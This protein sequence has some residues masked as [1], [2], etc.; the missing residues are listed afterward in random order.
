MPLA[1]KDYFWNKLKRARK[2]FEKRTGKKADRESITMEFLAPEFAGG[3]TLDIAGF[4]SPTQAIANA[5][6]MDMTGGG[7]NGVIEPNNPVAL[8]D[9][10]A[11]PSMIHEGE[12]LVQPGNGRAPNTRQVLSNAQ[13]NEIERRYNV[14]GMFTGSQHYPEARKQDVLKR[15][16]GDYRIRGY[17]ASSIDEHLQNVPE[18]YRDVAA[19][20]IREAESR[21]LTTPPPPPPP[22][23]PTRAPTYGEIIEA[24]PT[25]HRAAAERSL[26]SASISPDYQGYT[27]TPRAPA[28]GATLPAAGFQID[29][30]TLETP[31]TVAPPPA[32]TMTAP[33]LTT[34]GVATDA[35]TPP[36]PPP[37]AELPV[38]GPEITV[39]PPPEEAPVEPEVPDWAR[40]VY[41]AGAR[42]G[43][44]AIR[45]IA[46]GESPALRIAE[47]EALQQL[48]AR[49]E[50][51][52]IA[53]A[54]NLAQMGVSGTTAATLTAMAERGQ[55]GAMAQL[56]TDMAKQRGIS[57]EA[58]A[59]DLVNMGQA[60]IRVEL[61][62]AR[63]GLEERR[64]GLSEQQF[65]FL[66]Q[67]YG[68]QETTRMSTDAGVLSWPS[69]QQKYPNATREDY[70]LMRTA[71]GEQVGAGSR[72]STM[73][74]GGKSLA[75][76]KGDRLLRSAIARELG[77][78]P[79]DPSIDDEIEMRYNAYLTENKAVFAQNAE[80]LIGDIQ[81][82]NGTVDDARANA[83]LRDAIGA[84]LELD[85]R[86][87]NNAA[88]IDAEIQRRWAASRLTVPDRAW[89][90]M[91]DAGLIPEEYTD[92]PG[93]QAQFNRTIQDLYT[94]GLVDVDGNLIEGATVVWPWDDPDTFHH[95]TD[96]NGN[97]IDYSNPLPSTTHVN[98]AGNGT[99]YTN[100]VGGAVTFGDM[101]RQWN[102]MGPVEKEK[103]Y[104]GGVLDRE[105]FMRDYF[106]KD[107]INIAF[108]PIRNESDMAEWTGFLG[109]YSQSAFPTEYVQ[110]EGNE[111]LSGDVSGLFGYYD[112]NGN[113]Q[114]ESQ[115]AGKLMQAWK[116]LS[117]YFGNGEML[118][119]DKFA[120]I[121][122]NGSGYILDADGHVLNFDAGNESFV[123][124]KNY[125]KMNLGDYKAR[126]AASQFGNTE[127]F[128]TALRSSS[129]LGM[130]G[131][132]EGVL[133][134]SVAYNP[135]IYRE[136]TLG[137]GRSRNVVFNDKFASW[138]NDNK[139]KTFTY[140]GAEYRI[141]PDEPIVAQHQ[142][143]IETIGGFSLG[144]HA[145][146]LRVRNTE[147]GKEE[148]LTFD[149]SAKL[150]D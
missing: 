72:I 123:N 1:K 150:R 23:Q 107:K 67:K 95:Y 19:V 18:Q 112:E 134:R 85:P 43:Y 116:D 104:T 89:K 87:P 88:A 32:V 94:Q 50:Y 137:T 105:R 76:M 56:I 48:G 15:I 16:Q 20:G 102:Q 55:Q 45:D 52:D 40:D 141:D 30:P 86:D 98:L 25:Q 108:D 61:D 100:D 74:V 75:D 101:E 146:A 139:G 118:S 106:S 4:Q 60:G 84:F 91:T 121:W 71:S 128:P 49:Q 27:R 117:Q 28:P 111:Y 39:E 122:G 148:L 127:D 9:T 54:Q 46:R 129:E 130:S 42:E 38:G 59:R 140:N 58:A 120:A 133:H 90:N 99:E 44:G 10:T 51:D 83:A 81:D 96:W 93:L 65:G 17:Q 8:L 33:E 13:L 37:G 142:Y 62:R 114:H 36:P 97:D 69:F 35:I 132:G 138:A 47:R 136:A 31:T 66:K 41:G 78:G 26:S 34:G 7:A 103:Y 11:G 80:R 126:D 143:D 12:L 131:T 22:Q 53:L 73:F 135:A 113:F 92:T 21:G 82:N 145:D 24:T 14:P 5:R 57:A 149:T 2:E 109:G 3:Q 68:D 6:R 77:V 115:S 29:M 63:V 125:W 64:V 124:K 119:A 70:D 110:I 147:T 79:D 144:F